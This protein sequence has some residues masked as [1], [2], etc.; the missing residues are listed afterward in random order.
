MQVNKNII[1]EAFDEFLE[2]IQKLDKKKITYTFS[3]RVDIKANNRN[4][5]VNWSSEEEF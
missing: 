3:G 5:N 2:F 1:F 4:F